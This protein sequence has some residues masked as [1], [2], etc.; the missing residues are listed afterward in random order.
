MRWDFYSNERQCGTFNAEPFILPNPGGEPKP[1]NGPMHD[2]G[3][4]IPPDGKL[5]A[6][7]R[8]NDLGQAARLGL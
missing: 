6:T 3:T 1:S 2:R 4:T 5:G 7:P 8:S